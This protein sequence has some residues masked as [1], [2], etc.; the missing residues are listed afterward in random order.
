MIALYKAS[1]AGVKVELIVR[2]ICSLR[3][4]IKGLSDNIKVR[5][6]VGRYLEHSRI[7]YFYNDGK[8]DIY[9]SSADWMYRN[10]DK[11]VETMT[12]IEEPLI[13]KELKEMLDLYLKDNVKARILLQDGSYTKVEA[14]GKIINAQEDMLELCKKFNSKC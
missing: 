5:S 11:R 2:G 6:I 13:K 7:Y 8:E 3:P 1:Q 10:L 9:I 4:S 12:I 14:E